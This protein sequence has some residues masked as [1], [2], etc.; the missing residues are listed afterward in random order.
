MNPH[1]HNLLDDR[2]EYEVQFSESGHRFPNGNK[3]TYPN[4]DGTALKEDIKNFLTS[5]RLIEWKKEV[6]R[7][8]IKK[9][10]EKDLRP[11]GWTTVCDSELDLLQEAIALTEAEK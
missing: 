8:N 3:I 11:T 10:V 5:R 4:F 6:E 2:K 9:E 1:Y 7:W